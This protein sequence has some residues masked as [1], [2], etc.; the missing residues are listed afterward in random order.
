MDGWGSNSGRRCVARA[1][2]THKAFVAAMMCCIA[3]CGLT[4]RLH[5]D[6]LDPHGLLRSTRLTNV[7]PVIA[8]VDLGC[9]PQDALLA[10]PQ[11]VGL[12]GREFHANLSNSMLGVSAS[13]ELRFD[14]GWNVYDDSEDEARATALSSKACVF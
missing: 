11:T 4:V 5:D 12:S 13:A 7:L 9:M 8:D 10:L 2:A 6:Q 3:Q 1:S 14:E